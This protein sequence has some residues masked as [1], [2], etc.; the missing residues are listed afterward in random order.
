MVAAPLLKGLVALGAAIVVYVVPYVP[1]YF[2]RERA[3]EV[4][5]VEAPGPLWE[6]WPFWTTWPFLLALVAFGLVLTLWRDYGSVRAGIAAV[7]CSCVLY[8]SV[9]AVA[10]AVIKQSANAGLNA[11]GLAIAPPGPLFVA[12]IAASIAVVI[13]RHQYRDHHDV[14]VYPPQTGT[15]ASHN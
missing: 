8:L 11:V 14:W 7:T 12:V 13:F 6:E 5:G 4:L 3:I 9:I 2:L 1:S 15:A 10:G